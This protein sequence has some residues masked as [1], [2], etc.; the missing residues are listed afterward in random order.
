[1]TD[2]R[3]FAAEYRSLLDHLRGGAPVEASRPVL[4]A[5][6][7]LW[8]TEPELCEDGRATRLANL[9]GA[10]SLYLTRTGELLAVHPAE[11]PGILRVRLLTG[12][13]DALWCAVA[14]HYP[15]IAPGRGELPRYWVL[16]E[17][18]SLTIFVFGVYDLLLGEVVERGTDHTLIVG[19]VAAANSAGEHMRQVA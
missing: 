12:S 2:L 11:R 17:S 7:G 5:C 16:R 14:E 4:E 1:M 6:F 19:R 9:P 18:V 8:S 15:G 10:G 13:P 3:P